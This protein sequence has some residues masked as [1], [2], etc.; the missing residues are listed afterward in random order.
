MAPRGIKTAIVAGIAAGLCSA[1]LVSPWRGIGGERTDAVTAGVA[2]ASGTPARTKSAPRGVRGP[3]EVPDGQAAQALGKQRAEGGAAVETPGQQAGGAPELTGREIEERHARLVA[4]HFREA[5]DVEWAPGAAKA[6]AAALRSVEGGG[7]FRV[8][9]V[10]C[11]TTTC[12]G[13]LEWQSYEAA[14]HG[15]RPA[16]HLYCEEVNCPRQIVLPEPPD[17]KTR[18][19]ASILF[20]CSKT[21]PL[22]SSGPRKR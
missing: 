12:V 22:G 5:V 20:D 16:L 9:D 2:G 18:Y 14:I 8:V 21:R 15:A 6:L 4:E 7:A 11:R 10:D 17:R 1:L 19:R 3:E 13:V